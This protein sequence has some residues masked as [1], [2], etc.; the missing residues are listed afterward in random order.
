MNLRTRLSGAW[1]LLTGRGD[2][3]AVCSFC[4]QSRFQVE[5]VIAGPGATAICNRC[6]FICNQV[7]LEH[8]GP[9]GFRRQADGPH[10]R[11]ISISLSHSEPILDTVERV[12]LE[13][14]LRALIAA[15][16]DSRLVGWSYLHG[17]DRFDLLTV[18]IETTSGQTAEDMQALAAAHW[19]RLRDISLAARQAPANG[20]VPP[21]IAIGETA[22]QA[23]RT[24][25]D[26]VAQ[27]AT[28]DQNAPV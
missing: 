11:T 15:L 22:M 27:A 2:D 7:L 9:P 17:Q 16:P 28:K 6:V 4:G 12:A 10:G 5:Q 24:F 14:L 21:L 26:A 23:A 8:A 19:Q 13:A 18:E 3:A 1:S 20:E 25:A